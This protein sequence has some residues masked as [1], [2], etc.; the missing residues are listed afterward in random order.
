MP[1]AF[2]PLGLIV[3]IALLILLGRRRLLR[4]ADY[5]VGAGLP[6][7]VLRSGS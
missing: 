5:V 4:D 3:G 7:A 6:L 1:R 2:G